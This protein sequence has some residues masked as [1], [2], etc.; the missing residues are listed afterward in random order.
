MNG[1]LPIPVFLQAPDS[2]HPFPDRAPPRSARNPVFHLMEHAHS[3]WKGQKK[4]EEHR[5]VKSPPQRHSKHTEPPRQ[6]PHPSIPPFSGGKRQCK[7]CQCRR[8]QFPQHR[9]RPCLPARSDKADSI[10]PERR[11][12]HIS[13]FLN[14][15]RQKDG[16]DDAARQKEKYHIDRK[17]RQNRRCRT[18]AHLIKQQNPRRNCRAGQP[19]TPPV[20]PAPPAHIPS[21]PPSHSRPP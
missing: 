6:L 20:L 15:L 4:Q 9:N 19:P 11:H 13:D 16:R 8:S 10:H 21:A 17:Q 14:Q 7:A 1:S 5:A 12:R 2:T 18:S 3:H